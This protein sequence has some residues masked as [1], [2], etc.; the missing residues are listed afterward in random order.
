MGNLVKTCHVMTALKPQYSMNVI[1]VGWNR[2]GHGHCPR[3]GVWQKGACCPPGPFWGFLCG[4]RD[5][6]SIGVCGAGQVAYVLLPSLA[7]PTPFPLPGVLLMTT[8]VQVS[9]TCPHDLERAPIPLGSPSAIA[10]LG[11]SLGLS[12]LPQ[13]NDPLSCHCL[14]SSLPCEHLESRD[15]AWLTRGASGNVCQ[16]E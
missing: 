4:L 6:W 14:G 10:G 12:Q 2:S 8:F 1:C 3:L 7:L 16:V 5:C 9:P 15:Q 13:K 11:S